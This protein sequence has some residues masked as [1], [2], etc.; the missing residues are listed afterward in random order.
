MNEKTFA[1]AENALNEFL[2]KNLQEL[3]YYN[4]RMIKS[5]TVKK[6]DQQ[7]VSAAVRKINWHKIQI[8]ELEG[9]IEMLREQLSIEDNTDNLEDQNGKKENT[10][11]D[12]C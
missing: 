6:V 9:E 11:Y 12:P 8:H 7:M 4:G 3:N 5:K 1:A 2:R 10:K